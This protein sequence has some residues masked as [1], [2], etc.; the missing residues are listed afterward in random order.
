MQDQAAPP[1]D[2]GVPVLARIR[3]A[4]ALL[5]GSRRMSEADAQA[6]YALAYNEYTQG[7]YAKALGCFQLLA[8]FRPE[9]TV[10]LLGL[11]LCQQRLGCYT[12]ASLAFEALCAQEPG[13]PGH[14]LA[15]A[16][17]RL[18]N[19]EH[20]PARQMLEATIRYCAA[21]DG[22]APVHARAQAMLELMRLAHEPVTA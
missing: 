17:C 1:T 20:D 12:E 3:Q 15:L 11:A 9:D 10:Y 19:Q 22:H 5:P 16:E 8:V 14:M 7:R 4:L 21:H 13:V 2:R 18:L 6:L